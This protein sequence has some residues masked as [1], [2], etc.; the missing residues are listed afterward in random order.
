MVI[1]T[2]LVKCNLGYKEGDVCRK[3]RI[4]TANDEGKHSKDETHLAY[5]TPLIPNTFDHAKIIWI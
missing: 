5:T 2:F 4:E 3:K 1:T